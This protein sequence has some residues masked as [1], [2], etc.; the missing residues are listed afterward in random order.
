MA[1]NKNAGTDIEDAPAD[2]R[3]EEAPVA[4]AP[5][6]P[7]AAQS[8]VPSGDAAPR[9]TPAVVIAGFIAA[10]AVVG[11]LIFGGGVLLGANLPGQGGVPS[12]PV[13]GGFPGGGGPSDRGDLEQP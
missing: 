9:R 1:Q 11:G 5:A 8:P 4:Q 12:F 7:P 3:A 13:D 10:G 2:V 6:A